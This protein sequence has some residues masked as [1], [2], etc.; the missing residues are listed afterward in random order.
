MF[1]DHCA[2]VE[3]V[4]CLC[5]C[6]CVPGCLCRKPTHKIY[7]P[8]DIF[9]LKR[10]LHTVSLMCIGVHDVHVYVHIITYNYECKSLYVPVYIHI[11]IYI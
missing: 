8:Q 2:D 3:Y 5:A 6:V 10:T 7:S 4:G 9:E 1:V 11:Y